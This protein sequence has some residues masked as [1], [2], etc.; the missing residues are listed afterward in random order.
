MANTVIHFI[1]LLVIY[2]FDNR[3]RKEKKP[4]E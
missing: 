2:K 4:M 1:P 3:I